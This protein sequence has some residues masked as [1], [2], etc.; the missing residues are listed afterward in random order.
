M[1]NHAGTHI[2]Y[3]GHVVEGGKLS[4]EFPLEYMMGTGLIIKVPEN[5]HTITKEVVGEQNIQPGDIVLFSTS[6]SL[7]DKKGPFF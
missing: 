1:M 2:D 7:I 4:H 5:Y 3:P 6:N